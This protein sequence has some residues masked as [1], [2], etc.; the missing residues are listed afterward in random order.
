MGRGGGGCGGGGGGEEKQS[1][2][3]TLAGDDGRQVIDKKLTKR[4]SD[5]A[6][7]PSPPRLPEQF[8][9]LG[10]QRTVAGA[11]APSL[12]VPVTSQLA[13]YHTAAAIN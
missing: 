9:L 12:C 10:M 11:T 4:F 1:P 3:P 2:D 7:S 13:R 5:G 6:G 8:L